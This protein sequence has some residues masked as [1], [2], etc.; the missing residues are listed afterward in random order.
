MLMIGV[1]WHEAVAS[2]SFVGQKL[3]L[4]EFALICNVGMTEVLDAS[5][6]GYKPRVMMRYSGDGGLTWGNYITETLGQAGDYE[7]NVRWTDL[8]MG[9]LFVIEVMLTDPVDFQIAIGKT[10]YTATRTFI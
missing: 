1:P 2:G 3:I 5:A 6:D 7:Q 9:T 10:R 4:N 8:G